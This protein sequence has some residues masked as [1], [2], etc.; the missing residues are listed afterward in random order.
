MS[1][2][3]KLTV[4]ISEAGTGSASFDGID[5]GSH[6][7]GIDISIRA[8][9]LTKITIHCHAAFSGDVLAKL[10]NVGVVVTPAEPES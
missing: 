1:G 2:F 9:E 8:N 5:I 10:E 3:A 4:D 7:S 6:I